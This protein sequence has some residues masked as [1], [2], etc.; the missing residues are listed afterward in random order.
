MKFQIHNEKLPAKVEART[1]LTSVF[2]LWVAEHPEQVETI[3]CCTLPGE[4]WAFEQHITKLAS[5]YPHKQF[6]LFCFENHKPRFET[7]LYH[8]HK[9][10]TH[11]CHGSRN[12]GYTHVIASPRKN[13]IIHFYNEDVESDPMRLVSRLKV[14]IHQ[15]LRYFTWLDFLGHCKPA[16]MRLLLKPKLPNSLVAYTFDLSFRKF[17]YMDATVKETAKKREYKV[18]VLDRDSRAE[19]IKEAIHSKLNESRVKVEPRM[20]H[21][22]QGVK[23]PMMTAAHLVKY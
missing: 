16:E 10:K 2:D 12:A 20:F 13:V 8:A 17:D 1:R 23:I 21:T 3:L 5:L 22:Y 4:S 19:I 9:D 15:Q 7:V 11:L 6:I 18:G 14:D